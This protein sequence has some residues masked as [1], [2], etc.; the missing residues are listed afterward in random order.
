[1]MSF[2]PW[3]LA[4]MEEEGLMD[5]S[6]GCIS[7][8]AKVLNQSSSSA[9]DTAEFREACYRSNVDPDS[10][11]QADLDRLQQKLR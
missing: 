5:T 3:M 2:E 4:A 1:M 11:S 6:E 7:R 8:V 9:I 10:F